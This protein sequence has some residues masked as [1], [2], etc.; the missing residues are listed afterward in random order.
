MF[1]D[2]RPHDVEGWTCVYE[3]AAQYDA[4][5]V[6]N[7]FSDQGIDSQ[8]LSMRDSAYNLSVSQMA[9]VYLYVPDNQLK[10]AQKALDEWKEG[11]INIDE[12]PED[13][14]SPEDE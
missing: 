13:A 2:Q 4:D 1:K 7:Y 6:Q 14:Q 8:I 10:Q 3:S 5:M 9:M 11:I 12:L